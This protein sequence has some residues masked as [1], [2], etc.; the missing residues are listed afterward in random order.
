MSRDMSL[1]EVNKPTRESKREA[2]G[3]IETVLHRLHDV[4]N[5]VIGLIQVI[6]ND[7]ATRS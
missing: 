2:N 3:V 1:G 5:N 4:E 7:F 6:M